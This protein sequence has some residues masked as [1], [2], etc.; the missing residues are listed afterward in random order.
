M[1]FMFE[2]CTDCIC[3]PTRGKRV[4]EALADTEGKW[5]FDRRFT[6][7]LIAL[8]TIF[9][10]CVPKD[11]G[12]LRHAALLGFMSCMFVVAVVVIRFF[13]PSSS[14]TLPP[15]ELPESPASVSAFLSSI[16][17]IFFAYQCHVSAVPIYASMRDRSPT[18]WLTVV[19]IGLFLCCIVY[20]LT[21]VFGY[22]SFGR[23]V[24]S[25][26]LLSYPAKD[27]LVIAARV[28]MAVAMVTSYP[29]L[30]FCG[31][32]AFLSVTGLDRF[33]IDVTSAERVRKE[34]KRRWVLTV[35]WFLGALSLSI[36]VP[37]ISD[38]ISVI[39]SLAAFFILIFPGMVI[40]QLVLEDFPGWHK[41]IRAV[42][43]VLMGMI[44]VVAGTWIFGVT[45]TLA[46]YHF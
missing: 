3:L 27:P 28:L 29:I 23:G 20:T 37:T 42:S 22:L 10:L 21:G 1:I 24:H 34:R 15:P 46:L 35:I 9:P 17:T 44:F 7:S 5:Y 4:F 6:I 43:Q 45:L 32:A 31:R 41:R 14:Q 33:T 30:H 19:G 26:I 11:I 40:M 13:L 18:S 16:P 36:T 8:L 39:G 12:F 2:I 38:V 25:D